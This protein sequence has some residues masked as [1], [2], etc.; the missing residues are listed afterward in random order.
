MVAQ[1]QN[2]YDSTLDAASGYLSLEL[3]GNVTGLALKRNLAQLKLTSIGAVFPNLLLKDI[4]L[5]S[6]RF[7][8]KDSGIKYT[9]V[10]FWYSHCVACIGEF[11]E[12][13][14]VY[15]DFKNKG[16]EI[17]GISTDREKYISNWKKIIA[18]YNL[19]WPQRLDMNGKQADSL[20]ILTFPSN[21]LCDSTGKIVL[22]D[23]QPAQL[24]V[25]LKD[26]LGDL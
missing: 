9:M 7:H 5:K 12:L 22:F 20:A 17:I 15:R 19:P 14:Q 16:F 1:V 25:F 6:T 18:Q 10:D 2:G 21:F 8:D 3:Q 13:K 26:K 23:L 24:A 11:G 4:N